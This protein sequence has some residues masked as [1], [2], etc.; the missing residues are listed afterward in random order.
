MAGDEQ[1]AVGQPVDGPAEAGRA[2]SDDLAVAVEID[3][4]DLL[5]APVGEPQP[6]VVPTRRLDI[7][8]TAQQDDAVF[9][10]VMRVTYET[11]PG[12]CPPN[13]SLFFRLSIRFGFFSAA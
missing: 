7:G 11:S 8:E 2:L 13:D 5:G 3:R 10:W 4:D 6:A 1:A 12:L 9:E